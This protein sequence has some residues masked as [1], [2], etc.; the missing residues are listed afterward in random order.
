[1]DEPI[2]LAHVVWMDR[3]DGDTH[4]TWRA[5][6]NW[7]LA[8]HEE[9]NSGEQH[10]FTD[11]NGKYHG[12]VPRFFR[13]GRRRGFK[14]LDLKNLGAPSGSKEFGPVTVV[15]TA[16]PSF[17]TE[18]V[19]V[20]WYRN[21][22]AFE[23]PIS[24]EDPNLGD[25]YYFV[26]PAK[27]STLVPP[28]ARSFPI[29][30]SRKSAIGGPGHDSIHY[31]SLKS[32]KLARRI[33]AYIDGYDPSPMPARRAAPKGRTPR[34]IDV[35]RRLKVELEAMN[36]VEQAFSNAG[37]ETSFVHLE[38]CGWDLTATR[39]GKTALVEIK[40]L[41]SGTISVEL[42]ANEYTSSKRRD[43]GP[44]TQ[45]VIAVVTDALDDN[46]RRV[47]LYRSSAKRWMETDCELRSL[48]GATQLRL[49]RELVAAR[50]FVSD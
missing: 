39:N 31:A 7:E 35:P 38:K 6:W 42:T 2:V 4:T 18:R 28:T 15:W 46:R 37:W 9:Q 49:D 21:A 50:F 29:A 36:A 13:R 5:A 45:Y 1:M 27:H 20:G 48:K 11:S 10:L 12:Y 16:T 22:T 40:G 17:G 33:R 26:A 41:S 43:H 23:H 19:I 24:S 8:E 25:R 3:Y 47:W 44:Q 32:P 30:L 34:V 14:R